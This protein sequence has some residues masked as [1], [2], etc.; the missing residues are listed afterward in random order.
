MPQSNTPSPLWR[1]L[2]EKRSGNKWYAT[3]RN[4]NTG[5]WVIQTTD[6]SNNRTG[7][8]ADTS[9]KY[10]HADSFDDSKKIA[11]ANAQYTALAVNNLASLAEALEGLLSSYRADFK[12]ITGAELNDTEAVKKA[13]AALASIS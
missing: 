10:I 6:T 5:E 7:Y 9:A 1:E 2:N 13:K 3:S 4:P 12:T 11:E 8:I